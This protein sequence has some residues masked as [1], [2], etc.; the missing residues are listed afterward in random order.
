MDESLVEKALSLIMAPP[1][2]ATQP[3]VPHKA[4]VP[5][6]QVDSGDPGESI[7]SGVCWRC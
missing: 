1:R 3:F 5:R 7:L 2:S 6:V 4:A